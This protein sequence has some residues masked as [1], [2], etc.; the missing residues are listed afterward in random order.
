MECC[1]I[2][3]SA[4]VSENKRGAGGRRDEGGRR[5]RGAFRAQRSSCKTNS[6][7]VS[8]GRCV[9]SRPGSSHP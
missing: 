6:K 5:R 1:G 7:S 3:L 4:A 9:F 2:N 8:R